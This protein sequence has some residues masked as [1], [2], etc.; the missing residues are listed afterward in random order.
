MSSEITVFN[1]ND[2]LSRTIHIIDKSKSFMNIA[3]NKNISERKKIRLL[4]LLNMFPSFSEMLNVYKNIE[5][6]DNKAYVKNF[7]NNLKKYEKMDIYKNIE[8]NNGSTYSFESVIAEIKKIITSDETQKG[9]AD[10]ATKTESSTTTEPATKT[11]PETPT[12][13]ATT[14]E[15]ATTESATTEPTTTAETKS[16]TKPATKEESQEATL[17]EESE[18]VEQPIIDDSEC[19]NEQSSLY[20]E[21]ES[22]IEKNK[23]MF[24]SENFVKMITQTNND[25]SNSLKNLLD[26]L[27]T[28][29]Y[30]KIYEHFSINFDQQIEDFRKGKKPTVAIIANMLGN[31]QYKTIIRELF[32]NLKIERLKENF[33]GQPLLIMVNTIKSTF[34]SI[35]SGANSAKKTIATAGS[36]KDILALVISIIADITGVGAPFAASSTAVGA[37]GLINIVPVLASV[38]EAV[39]PFI[40]FQFL[41][42]M[43]MDKDAGQ[44]L[45]EN[46]PPIMVVINML[47]L[48]ISSINT[49]VNTSNICSMLHYDLGDNRESVKTLLDSFYNDI[50]ANKT[51]KINELYI[52]LGQDMQPVSIEDK[53]LKLEDQMSRK[54]GIDTNTL[55]NLDM[56]YK[57]IYIV[58]INLI[59]CNLK[60]MLGLTSTI[61][62]LSILQQLNIKEFKKTLDKLSAGI[63]C[64]NNPINKFS[65]GL[66]FIIKFLNVPTDAI[67][68]LIFPF[69]S[70]FG[71]E[72]SPETDSGNCPNT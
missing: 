58:I 47:H 70:F 32:N 72:D 62:L 13:S 65:N 55:P 59:I 60:D 12:E 49:V 24:E 67:G 36:L 46:F 48:V 23:T 22:V 66:S 7:I 9:G 41:V 20:K 14:T 10:P 37:A 44:Y 51:I 34:E 40:H 69:S 64:P 26:L 2:I 6:I 52:L 27:Q 71:I 39:Q 63:N 11:E 21:L 5:H 30:K 56:V 25:D 29:P 8:S 50:S 54:V 28:G 16:A 43:N 17:T 35:K 38:G 53:K 3:N 31:P 18:L 15:P 45:L 1:L 68:D 19:C 33:K 57:N 42:S 61:A 4:R